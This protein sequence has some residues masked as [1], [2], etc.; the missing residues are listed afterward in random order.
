MIPVL[1]IDDD[2]ELTSMLA[3]YLRHEGFDAHAVHDGAAGVVAAASGRYAIAVLDELGVDTAHV[4]GHDW[5][6][7]IGWLL[8]AH[9]PDRVRTLWDVRGPAKDQ[10]LVTRLT[11]QV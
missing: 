11:R 2:V 5:G 1:L 3:Q 7:Q 4:I 10:R 6:A 9:H 8:A